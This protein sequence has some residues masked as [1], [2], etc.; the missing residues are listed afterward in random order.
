VL[1]AGGRMWL[2]EM[3]AVVR[4]FASTEGRT[5]SFSVLTNNS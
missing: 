4:R 1:L 5:R 3:W 2:L